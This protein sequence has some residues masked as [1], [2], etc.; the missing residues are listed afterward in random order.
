M[1]WVQ[2]I[3]FSSVGSGVLGGKGVNP[4]F[5]LVSFVGNECSWCE[6]CLLLF[7]LEVKYNTQRLF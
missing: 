4:F 1:Y 3:H 5:L 2:V 6:V 7:K